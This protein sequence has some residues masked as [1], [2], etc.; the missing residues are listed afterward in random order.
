VGGAVLWVLVRGVRA[1]KLEASGKRLIAGIA[2]TFA[3]GNAVACAAVG[4][5]AYKSF[6]HVF[7]RHSHTPAANLL[8][9]TNLLSWTESET[10]AQFVDPKLTE[11][12]EPWTHHQLE[13]RIHRRPLWALAVLGSLAIVVVTALQGGSAAECAALSGLVLFC[14]LPMTSYDYTWLIVL[15]ALARRRPQILKALL[16]FSV[17]SHALCLFAGEAAMTGYH[18]IGSVACAALLLYAADLRGIMEWL[19]ARLGP[20]EGES[21]S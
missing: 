21:S 17:G 12:S 19:A 18:L 16:A 15:V 7:N 20:R 10:D 14:L 6:A 9:L 5:G 13:R 3:L 1:K 2:I 11:S 4:P 8:G